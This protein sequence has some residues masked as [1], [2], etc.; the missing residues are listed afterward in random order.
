MRRAP[1]C[2]H[3]FGRREV[4][5]DQHRQRDDADREHDPAEQGSDDRAADDQRPAAR[6][7]EHHRQE[8]GDRGRCRPA[9]QGDVEHPRGDQPQGED[10]EQQPGDDPHVVDRRALAHVEEVPP[11]RFEPI[12]APAG[13]FVEAHGGDRAEQTDA[14]D[15]REEERHQRPVGGHHHRGEAD[16]GVDQPGEHEIAAHR[17]EVVEALAQ[18]QAQVLV[19]DLADRD[20]RSPP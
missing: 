15:D 11:V 9:E 1:R 17:P 14:R 2:R 6:R 10:G 19:A 3:G 20:A 13:H 12:L 7:G 18:R 5:V 8:F 4:A 16:E